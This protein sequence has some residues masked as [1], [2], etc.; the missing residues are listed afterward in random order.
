LSH[1]FVNVFKVSSMLVKS[2][3]DKNATNGRAMA[4]KDWLH[5]A[6][7]IRPEDRFYDVNATDDERVARFHERMDRREAEW[8]AGD[9]TA[10]GFAVTDCGWNQ[11]PLP[12]WLTSAVVELA[13]LQMDDAEK[14][15]R[16]QFWIHY[17]RWNQVVVLRQQTG[18][19]LEQCCAAASDRL[20]GSFAAGEENTVGSSYKLIQSAGGKDAVLESYKLALQRQSER[21]KKNKLRAR[22][23]I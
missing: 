10:I 9:I 21:R 11:Q 12:S 5:K 15:G 8:R 17:V 20:A 3:R 19:S 4:V 2:G 14:R 16:R 1:I 13:Y 7:R 6:R 23:S 22:A 18:M